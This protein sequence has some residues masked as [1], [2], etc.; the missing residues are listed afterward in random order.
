MLATAW[1]CDC[2]G[3]GSVSPV[4]LEFM[5]VQ[6][7]VWASSMPVGFSGVSALCVIV[8]VISD[9]L[10]L[11]FGRLRKEAVFSGFHHVVVES[12]A[13]ILLFCF[14]LCREPCSTCEVCGFQGFW[15]GGRRWR[16]GALCAIVCVL[17]VP[18]SCRGLVLIV[19]LPAIRSCCFCQCWE[20]F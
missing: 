18:Y 1:R 11:V 20:L 7:R 19:D 14:G 6:K 8:F 9:C 17:A 15:R 5:C 2:V 10:T 4:S 13:L 3:T 12:T 16:G